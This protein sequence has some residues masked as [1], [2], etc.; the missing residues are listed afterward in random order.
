MA[1]FVDTISFA[2]FA[3]GAVVGVMSLAAW[4]I[5]REERHLSLTG[6]APDRVSR[7]IRRLMGVGKRDVDTELERLMRELVRQ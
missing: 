6:Q 4:A 1:G 7:G 5:R 2:V 3:M